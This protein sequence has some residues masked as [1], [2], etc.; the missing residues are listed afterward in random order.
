MTVVDPYLR[1]YRS[2]SRFLL[3]A[4]LYEVE[5]VSS[6]KVHLNVPTLPSSP[7]TRTSVFPPTPP[8][9]RKISTIGRDNHEDISSG[10]TGDEEGGTAGES[11]PAPDDAK[12]AMLADG[13]TEWKGERLTALRMPLFVVEVVVVG[14]K[15]RETFAYSQRLTAVKE[16]ALALIDKAVASTQVRGIK[17]LQPFFGCKRQRREAHSQWNMSDWHSCI[18]EACL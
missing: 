11:V 8:I 12:M 3:R 18:P 2:F 7:A 14:E 15:G 13:R 5:I 1:H 16:S 10:E 17:Y 4:C 9:S 6:N